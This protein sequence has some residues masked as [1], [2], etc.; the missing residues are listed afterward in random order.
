MHVWEN[1]IP[2]NLDNSSWLGQFLSIWTISLNLDNFSQLGQ[3][4]SIWTH[5]VALDCVIPVYH[6]PHTV[7][8]SFGFSDGLECFRWMIASSSL[9]SPQHYQDYEQNTNTWLSYTCRHESDPSHRPN[10]NSEY[11]PIMP[12]PPKSTPA[13]NLHPSHHK[14]LSV[15]L[16]ECGSNIHNWSAIHHPSK[17]DRVREASML[18]K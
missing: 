16:M 11:T 15:W 2:L 18:T 10:S 3:F 13:Q 7:V 17:A 1:P 4:L 9:I 6:N 5:N 8:I 14:I 12:T